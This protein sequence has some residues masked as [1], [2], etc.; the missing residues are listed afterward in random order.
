LLLPPFPVVL[1]TR[2]WNRTLNHSPLP[3]STFAWDQYWRDGRLA[4][5]GGEAGANYQPAIAEGWR[6]FFGSMANGARVLDICTGNG[7]VARL[8]AE[9]ASARNARVT[10]DAVDAAELH[11]MGMGA[12]ADMIRFLPRTPAE[13]LPFPDDSFDFIVG[14]Y[15]IEYT[16]LDR[17][18]AELQRVSHPHAR[19]RFVTHASNSIVVQGARAQLADVQRLVQTGIFETAEALVR[20]T[21]ADPLAAGSAGA[22]NKFLVALRSLRDGEATTGDLR[23]YRN[24][25]S[26]LVHAI[27][28]LPQLGPAPVLDKIAETATAIKAHHARLS[29]MCRAALD[30]PSAEALTASAQ[31]AWGTKFTLEPLVRSDGALFGWVIASA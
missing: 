2:Q 5:C 14:Q 10:I 7:A 1:N 28:H 26:V 21:T 25:G 30:T 29:A 18:L 22:R 17:T 11:P 20:T 19:L 3:D 24:V 27:Q 8:A 23:M 6:R 9:V 13:H 16:E 4:S 31:R 12:G 15:A